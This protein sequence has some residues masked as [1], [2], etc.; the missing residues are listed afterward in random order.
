MRSVIW[1]VFVC[2]MRDTLL[3]RFHVLH[4]FVS[5]FTTAFDDDC[6]TCCQAC[7]TNGFHYWCLIANWKYVICAFEEMPHVFS[8]VQIVAPEIAIK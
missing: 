1:R 8:T 2:N 3:L 7:L 4:F 5:M 6:H